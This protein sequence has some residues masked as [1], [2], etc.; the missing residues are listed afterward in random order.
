MKTKITP[1]IELKLKLTDIEFS[2][3]RTILAN[4]KNIDS[5]HNNLVTK[6]ECELEKYYNET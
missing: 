5:E 4:V 3:L 1:Y 6:L 2:Y